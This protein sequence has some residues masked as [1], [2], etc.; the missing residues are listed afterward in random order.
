MDLVGHLSKELGGLRLN[1][2]P[3]KVPLNHHLLLR[4]RLWDLGLIVD[5]VDARAVVP[6]RGFHNPPLLRIFRQSLDELAP[7]LRHHQTF[8]QEVK[9]VPTKLE[10]HGVEAAPK[11]ILPRD[12]GEAGKR[13]KL[14]VGMALHERL[15]VVMVLRKGPLHNDLVLLS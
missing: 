11:A 9:V 8:L 15:R 13:L 12:L 2:T 3:G 4:V 1:L 14:D 5:E 7:L 6:A 10:L